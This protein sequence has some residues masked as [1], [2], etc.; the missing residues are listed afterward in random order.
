MR[1]H[2]A[3]NQD[4]YLIREGMIF[5][6]RFITLSTFGLLLSEIAIFLLA[7]IRRVT[8]THLID[9]KDFLGAVVIYSFYIFSLFVVLSLI[10]IIISIFTKKTVTHWTLWLAIVLILWIPANIAMLSLS[11]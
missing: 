6:N 3:P 4:K 1:R 11:F 5:M 8:N 2:I 7:L 10:I 9:D